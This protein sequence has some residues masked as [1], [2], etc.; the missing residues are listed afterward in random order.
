MRQKDY[1]FLCFALFFVSVSWSQQQQD[2]IMTTQ[3]GQREPSFRAF[4]IN[5]RMTNRKATVQI[6]RSTKK[7]K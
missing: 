3:G 5:P 1:L 4:T 2:E 6:V 7:S